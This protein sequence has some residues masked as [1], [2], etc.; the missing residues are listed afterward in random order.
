[1]PVTTDLTQTP[2][3]GEAKLFFQGD[4]IQFELALK[5]PL[6]GTAWVR[7]NLGRAA[8]IRREIVAA[9]DQNESPLAKAW[10]DL[11]M[12]PSGKNR[13]ILT[14]P[15]TEVGYFEAKCFFLQNDH[16]S[17]FWPPGENCTIKVEPAA[18]CGANTIYNAF[19]RQFGPNK[20]ARC[21][22]PVDRET[23]QKLDANGYTV[24]PPSGTFRDLVA[25]LDFIT[26]T[27]GCRYVLLLPVHPVPTTYARMGRFGSPYAALN[28]KTVSP[29]LAQF[30]LSATPTEQF[31]ELITAIHACSAKV[32]MDIAINH[33]GWAARL[34]DTHPH[35]LVRDDKGNIEQPGAWGVTWADLTRLD[36]QHREL[37]HYMAAVFLHWCR[38]GVDGFRCDA[39]YMIPIEAWRYIVAVVRQQ[40]PD[41]IFLLEGLGGPVATTEALLT[42]AGLNWAYSELFQNDDRQAIA[43][44]LPQAD[45]LNDTAGVMVHFAETHD[46]NRLAA[47]SK[48]WAQM[49]T[50]VCALFSRF[51]AFGF[52][53]GVEWLA[54]EKIDVHSASSLNWGSA[55]NQVAH[56]RRLQQLLANHPAFSA[57]V[58][59]KLIQTG[60]GNYVVILRRH[61]P[62]DQKIVVAAN[63]DDTHAATAYWD[64]TETAFGHHPIWD[65][66][67]NEPVDIHRQDSEAAIELKPGQVVCL[68]PKEADANLL[69]FTGTITPGDPPFVHRQRLRAKALQG[70]VQWRGFNDVS[71][72]DPDHLADLLYQSAAQLARLFI[73]KEE[74]VPLIVWHWP[75]DGRR[76][77]MI[78]PG[79]GLWVRSKHPFRFQVTTT[80]NITIANETSLIGKNDH[81]TVTWPS[82]P[83]FNGSAKL[84]V[85]VYINDQVKTVTAP[86][87]FLTPDS[88]PQMPEAFSRSQVVQLDN[89]KLFL[90]TN[91]RGGMLRANLRW[92]ELDSRYD[93]L[94]AANLNPHYPED[95]WIM[96][97]RCRAWVVFQ[98]YSTPLNA[99][100]LETFTQK[101]NGVGVWHFAVPTGQGAHVRL[102]VAATMVPDQ[103]RAMISFYRKPIGGR[104]SVLTDEL[105][106]HLILRPDVEDRNFHD[107]TK[108]HAGPEHHFPTSVTNNSD[109]VFFKPNPQRILTLTLPGATYTP[110]PEW[111]YMV[112]RPLEKTRGLDSDSDLFSP[113]YFTVDL[114]GDCVAT[115]DASISENQPVPKWYYD[116]MLKYVQKPLK[117]YS[118]QPLSSTLKNALKQY[119]VRR[120]PHLSVIAGFPW[121]LDWGR[122]ALIVVRGMIAAGMQSEAKSVLRQFGRFEKKG[123][124]PNMIRGNEAGD[125]NTADAPLWF[126]TVCAD[127]F[128]AEKNHTFLA[129]DCGGRTLLQVLISIA[130][131][132]IVGAPNGV[133]MDPDS[134]LIFSPIHYTWMDTNHPAGTPRQGFPVELQALWYAAL[135]LLVEIDPDDPRWKQLVTQVKRSISDY[136]Y[137]P[138]EGYL[139][140][141]LH[142][143]PG[144]TAATA[145]VDD[146]LR[147]NQ[148]LAV[149]LEAVENLALQRSI[150]DAC[151][152]LLVPGA[153]R[154]LADRPVKRPLPVYHNGKLLNDPNQPYQGY[155]QGDEDTQRKPAYHNGTAWTWVFPVFCEAYAKVWGRKGQ[156]IAKAYLSS[157]A[158]LAADGCVGHIPE[159]IDGNAPHQT[160]G[161]DA[162][163]W[164]VSEWLR[165]WRLLESDLKS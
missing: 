48:T 143:E 7:T 79:F 21:K 73:S 35:W 113:G 57:A 120:D 109:T 158:N 30:D 61:T 85:E 54:E 17:P 90:A 112:H 128:G 96:L 13:Y 74:P 130:E 52:A 69:P 28:F 145:E 122:D 141:C 115:L 5:R 82:D 135:N 37:W 102:A 124:L 136:Y 86:I 101:A 154:S 62:T 162:Q 50:A 110:E 138:D 89:N 29:G 27:L 75:Q 81:F 42:T 164:G 22:P 12:R 31:L 32:L 84:K 104:E 131:A 11:P 147:P 64:N 18:T 65:L 99:D 4:T 121:F 137:F 111:H 39:G 150:V 123:T 45:H 148:L 38:R 87:R 105:P 70:V 71:D 78:P 88:D 47:R 66:M 56:V 63:L 23:I 92:G 15:F 24:I 60:S 19:V 20:A 157:S 83:A 163:A 25:E 134:G 93:A 53:N 16:P 129:E 43:H 55:E 95:R 33:T 97:T 152:T 142:A 119:V 40:F 91:G 8:T 49:R 80:K 34:H 3:P 36:Y 14:L 59:T 41:T 100:C 77:V 139:A 6:R 103:N 165:V 44:Y 9:V 58:E 26:Q 94:L 10:F 67:T 159:I 68:T 126:F 156:S 76:E 153:I 98:G 127:L 117:F 146:A 160:R 149:T 144:Q 161:C 132:M 2:A 51:G 114:V 46:N 116:K 107:V 125:R 155:Y 140:D 151:E 106:I 108:A 72:L 118:R 1:M 133:S